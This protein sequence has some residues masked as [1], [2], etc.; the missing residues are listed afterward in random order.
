[1]EYIYFNSQCSKSFWYDLFMEHDRYPAARRRFPDCLNENIPGSENATIESFRD[2]FYRAMYRLLL[3]GA[4]LARPYMAPVFQAREERN[5]RFFVAFGDERYWSELTDTVEAADYHPDEADRAYIRRYPVYN[6]DVADWTDVGRW[7]DREYNTIFGP[8]A[9]WVIEDGRRRELD[10]PRDSNNAKPDW[11]ENWEDVGAVREL[12]LLMVAY[13]HFN[14]NF[15][16]GY[17]GHNPN[18]Q[19]KGNRTVSIVRF[20]VFKVEQIT[21]PAAL[22]DLTHRNLWTDGD[23]TLNGTP[24]EDLKYQM[25]YFRSMD[26]LNT[27]S[28]SGIPLDEEHRGPPPTLALWRFALRHYLN[29]TFQP[30][31]FWIPEDLNCRWWREVGRGDIFM[32]PNWHLVQRYEPGVMTW[33][34]RYIDQ[35]TTFIST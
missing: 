7:R 26:D 24:G 30:G 32:N 27:H 10:T 5:G 3:A 31:A 21:M 12:M 17:N 14:H 28:R 35:T 11:A 9:S 8:F 34:Y 16:D 33:D 13:D 15:E 25:D 23:P 22:E 2:G 20:G 6:F 1:M 19:K 4:L 29:L 18:G